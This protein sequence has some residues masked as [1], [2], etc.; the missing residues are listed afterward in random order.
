MAE[1]TFILSQQQYEALIAQA[2]EGTKDDAGTIDANK[3]RALDDFLKL[4]EKNNGITRDGLWVQ[5]QELD[6]PLPPDT[7]FPYKWPP[8]KRFYIELVTRKVAK[9]DVDAVIEARSKNAHNVLVTPD[10]GARVGW[11]GVD[12]YFVN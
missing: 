3:A 8:E 10:P 9:V 12:Q 1:R 7:E 2:R 4:I 5:W 11:T 6:E